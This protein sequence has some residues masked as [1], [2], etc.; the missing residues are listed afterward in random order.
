MFKYALL[1]L[2]LCL[3]L[4]C[5]SFACHAREALPPI[6]Q[7]RAYSEVKQQLLD[8]GWQPLQNVA[9][10]QSSLYAQTLAQ[11]GLTEVVDCISMAL[12]GCR[13]HFI[14]QGRVLEIQTITRQLTVENIQFV[15]PRRKAK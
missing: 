14:R 5:V 9:I 4:T 3:S 13:F 10:D 7:G 11:Q 8:Q 15:K 6:A 1:T 2:Y 12:D